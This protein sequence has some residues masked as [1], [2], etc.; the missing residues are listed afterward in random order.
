MSTVNH[1]TRE[2]TIKIVYVGPGRSGKT[3]A[4]KYI[5]ENTPEQNRGSLINLATPGDRTVYFDF[6]P[7]RFPRIGGYSVRLKIFTIQG[8]VRYSATYRLVLSGADGIVFMA[9]STGDRMNENAST[10]SNIQQHLAEQGIDGKSFPFIFQYNKQD[11]KEALSI[12]EMNESL[13]A[14]DLIYIDTCA[15]TG[16]GLFEGL[17]IITK[18]IIESIINKGEIEKTALP[19]WEKE[20]ISFSGR[21][22]VNAGIND[23]EYHQDRWSDIEDRPSWSDSDNP[24]PE[25]TVTEPDDSPKNDFSEIMQDSRPTMPAPSSI[26]A[27]NKSGVTGLS[28]SILW[29]FPRSSSIEEM[30]S[31]ISQGNAD[32]ALDII[33]QEFNSL[34]EETTSGIADMDNHTAALAVGLDGQRLIEFLTICDTARQGVEPDMQD[35]LKAYVLLLDLKIILNK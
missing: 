26:P 15:K 34:L 35:V 10:L 1:L 4:L 23:P 7:I 2:I 28:F 18:T 14:K 17:E 19:D 33:W 25:V 31:A 30:E 3:S 13:N 6:L 27:D 32:L 9:D 11:L 12:H 24:L 16:K 8:E 22:V 21:T 5:H 20:S 29:E